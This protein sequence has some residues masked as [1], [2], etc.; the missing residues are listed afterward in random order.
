MA[1]IIYPYGVTEVTV[2]DTEKLAVFSSDIVEIYEQTGYPNFPS[3]WALLY[4]TAVGETYTTAAFTG[5]TVV[6]IEAKASPVYYETGAAPS[7]SEP[8]TDITASDAT[9]TITGLA[10]AQG[11]YVSVIGGTSS[12][13][14]NAGGAAKLT[15]GTP[16][17]TGVGG[18]VT[19]L[20]A[21]GGATSGA[22]GAVTITAGAGTAGNGNGGSVTI[23][24]GAN[25]GSG[26]AGV[27]INNGLV[28]K[29]Q[30]APTAKTVSATLTAAEIRAGIITVNQGAAGAS[31]LQLPTGTAMVTAFPDIAS[32]YAFD[33]SVI[34]TSTVDAE[35]ASVTTNTDW[36][37]VGSMDVPAYS[38]AGSLD[39]SA[40]FTARRTGATTW[41]LYR[42]A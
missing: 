36:T 22:G 16:G 15:G 11:G 26:L 24:A 17:A 28:A 38:A 40:R 34:N 6:R 23:A 25:H 7:V 8:Q 13:T 14:G 37:L 2:P 21:A 39:S 20:A 5:N 41:V 1:T 29:L 18:A 33:F 19:V 10:A 30:G 32:G 27:I 42:I 3:S 9:F 35:D 31:A 12:T 4:T